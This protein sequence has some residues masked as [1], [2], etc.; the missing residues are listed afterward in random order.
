[1]VPFI[2]GAFHSKDGAKIMFYSF[3]GAKRGEIFYR[4][5]DA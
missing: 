4:A 2:G 1:M 5:D 3:Y